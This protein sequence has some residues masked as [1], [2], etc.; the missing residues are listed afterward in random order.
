MM[1]AG[2]GGTLRGEGE[3]PHLGVVGVE[4]EDVLEF[5]GVPILDGLVLAAREE[6]VRVGHELH[7][8]M[9]CTP[10]P[11]TSHQPAATSRA[12][13]EWWGGGKGGRGERE[14]ERAEAVQT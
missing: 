5:V 14:R 11:P 10:Q 3:G 2:G 13:C 7:L 9:N 8:A 12:C 4:G 1:T 6:V